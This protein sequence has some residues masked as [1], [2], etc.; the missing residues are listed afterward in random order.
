MCG[1]AGSIDLAGQRQPDKAQL[2]RMAAALVH[3][4]P[5]DSGFL[6]EPGIGLAHRR[7]SIVG[8]EDGRQ[9]IFNEDRTVAVICNGEL[10]DF[11]ER[12]A[13]TDQPF[14]VNFWGKGNHFWGAHPDF[15]DTPA[16]TT[17]SAQMVEHD[18]N[19]GRILKTLKD[20]GIELRQ[21]RRE[22]EKVIGRGSGAAHV[23]ALHQTPEAKAIIERAVVE[24]RNH[25]EP[26]VGT[27]HILLALMHDPDGVPVKV[28]TTLGVSLDKVREEI[29][30]V[31]GPDPED[32]P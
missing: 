9:P 26:I 22:V 11:V 5:D 24:A 2:R 6:F 23:D 3:R 31:F 27:E 13:K 4:G 20:L 16:G 12:R 14:F 30:A 17:T 15:R 8:L 10:F 29:H 28:L 19:T 7:L 21:V 18:Y 32:R 1:I 25:H